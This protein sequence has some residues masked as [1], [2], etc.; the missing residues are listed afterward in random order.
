[1]QHPHEPPKTRARCAVSPLILTALPSRT[2]LAACTY[3]LLRKQFPAFSILVGLCRKFKWLPLQEYAEGL[4]PATVDLLQHMMRPQNQSGGSRRHKKNA[5]RRRR[6]A[7]P[8]VVV[9]HSDPSVWEPSMVASELPPCPPP[10]ASYDSA[11]RVIGRTSVESATADPE[12][13]ARCNRMDQA[14]LWPR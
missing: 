10:E 8:Y 4:D 5:P 9:C 1:M 14:R 11:Y 6:D 13:V 2:R 12:L 3:V 7:P